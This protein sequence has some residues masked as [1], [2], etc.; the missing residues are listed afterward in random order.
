MPIIDIQ[1]EVG[2][3]KIEDALFCDKQAITKLWI[4]SHSSFNDVAA[5]PP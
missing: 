1:E 5:L 2:H 3:Q 4:N